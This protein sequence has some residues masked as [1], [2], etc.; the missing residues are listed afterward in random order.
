[1]AT[2]GGNMPQVPFGERRAIS[3]R[4]VGPPARSVRN[5]RVLMKSPMRVRVWTE[6]RPAVGVP[7]TMSVCPVYRWIKAARAARTVM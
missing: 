3:S 7:T 2:L 4:N 5:T 1:M 6:A